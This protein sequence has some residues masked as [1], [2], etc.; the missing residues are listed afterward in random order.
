MNLYVRAKTMRQQETYSQY[1]I[2][3]LCSSITNEKNT[4]LSQPKKVR[5]KQ[6]FPTRHITMRNTYPRYELSKI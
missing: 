4:F 6:K 5:G 2:M 3:C 1:C